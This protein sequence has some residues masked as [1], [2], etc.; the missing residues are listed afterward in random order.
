MTS[1]GSFQGTRTKG[2]VGVVEIAVNIA[3]MDA[4]SM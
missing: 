1:P 2:T 4:K 3:T